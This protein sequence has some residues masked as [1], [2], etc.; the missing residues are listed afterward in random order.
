MDSDGSVTG[1]G[2]YVDD[3]AVKR[4]HRPGLG[5]SDSEEGVVLPIVAFSAAGF[6]RGDANSDGRLN[7][8]DVVFILRLLFSGAAEGGC[9][10]AMDSDNDGGIDITDA[11]VLLDYLFLGG[12]APADPGPPGTECGPDPDPAGSAGDLGCEDYRG[13]SP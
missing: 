1:P 13:C 6:H 12:P 4:L 3:V 5:F 8:T 7:V 9:R 11:I 10:E 2:W